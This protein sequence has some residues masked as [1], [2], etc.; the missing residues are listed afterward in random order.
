MQSKEDELLEQLKEAVEI[1]RATGHKVTQ[2]T[3]ARAVGVS[4]VTFKQYPRA[5]RFLE[6]NTKIQ[7]QIHENN[8]MTKVKEAIR[9]LEENNCKITHSTICKQLD[10]PTTN[11]HFYPSVI[12]FVQNTVKEKQKQ[13]KEKQLSLEEELLLQSVLVAIRQLQSQGLTISY[14]AIAKMLHTDP[15]KLKKFPED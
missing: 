10:V 15:R 1:L 4:R 5:V 12:V 3:L 14:T 9:V 2:Q 7:V 6:E 13:Y 8:M 11:L